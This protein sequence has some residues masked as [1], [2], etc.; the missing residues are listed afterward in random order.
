MYRGRAQVNLLGPFPCNP[1]ERAAVPRRCSIDMAPKDKIAYWAGSPF[2]RARDDLERAD[3]LLHLAIRGITGLLA[4]PGLTEALARFPFSGTSTEEIEHAKVT[5]DFAQREVSTGFPVLHAQ[6]VIALWV[7]LE[8]LVRTFLAT[9]LRNEP[10]AKEVDAVR[11]LKVSLTHYEAMDEEE[12]CFYLVELL[13][14]DAAPRHGI[15]RFECLLR[16]FALSG[17]FHEGPRRNLYEL[18]HV[19]NL[20]VHRA[21][22]VDRK[23]VNACPWLGL[24]PGQTYVVDHASCHR[25][26]ASTL[27]YITEI[28][29]RVR[30]HFGW[31]R[32]EMPCDAGHSN[33]TS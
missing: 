14:R 27:E 4:I 10:R 8:D 1:P 18:Y 29:Y 15:E 13:E 20:L 22:R 28:I 32:D 12:R 24:A 30:E 19:R 31:A 11:K 6:A 17:P 16:L 33:S 3:R 5:A 9:W 26:Q 2:F 21:G 7:L 23:F 25:Y